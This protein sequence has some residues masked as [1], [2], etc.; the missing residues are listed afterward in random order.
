MKRIPVTTW[1]MALVALL[2]HLAPRGGAGPAGRIRI[3]PGRWTVPP[4]AKPAPAVPWQH[5]GPVPNRPGIASVHVASMAE[6][7]PGRLA[8]A[9]Y[10]GSREGARDV[11]I[12]LSTRALG[13]SQAWTPPVVIMDQP[14][15]Q[16]ELDRF[17]KKVGNP[18]IFSNGRGG[19]ELLYVSIAVGGWSG[20]SL[21]WKSSPDGGRS[22]TPSRRLVLSP[23]FNVS[24]LVKNQPVSLQGGGWMVPIYHELFGKF[25]ELL[26]LDVPGAGAF[27]TRSRAFGGRTAFQPAVVP[28]GS[29]EALLLCRTAGAQTEVFGSLSRDGGLHWESPA[30]VGLPN[31][32]SGL[33]AIRLADGRIL[34]AINDA[35]SGRDS[36]RLVVSPDGGRS[37]QRGAIVASEPGAEFSYPFLLQSSDGTIHLVFTWKRESI[38][39]HEFNAAWLDAS[40][41]GEAP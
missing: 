21:N 33:D 22:W 8:A 12:F 17:V 3:P 20:S 1:A 32:G 5:E 6:Y 11:A 10:G 23:F 16:R 9:W 13:D 37:W 38:R 19:L 15:A 30:P 18:L 26:W 2:L 31:P 25:T 39:Y 35:R 36:L 14:M 29:D 7:A 40:L 41:T 24:E 4:P 27:A 34:A 28:T